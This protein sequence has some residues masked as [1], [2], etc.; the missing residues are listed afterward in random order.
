MKNKQT[1]K[2]GRPSIPV[3]WPET[4]FT[5]K[6]LKSTLDAAGVKL[7]KVA[8][9]LKINRAVIAGELEMVGKEPSTAGRKQRIFQKAVT[10]VL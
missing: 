2:R 5:I 1:S 8:I 4:K 9:Q 3:T 7:S 6:E 10:S